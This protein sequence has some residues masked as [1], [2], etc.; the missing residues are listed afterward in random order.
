[1]CEKSALKRCFA[2]FILGTAFLLPNCDLAPFHK[3]PERFSLEFPELPPAWKSLLG[4]PLWRIEW[5][6]SEGRKEMMTVRGKAEIAL[7]QTW[8]NPVIAMPFW[9]G[10]GIGHGI[11][12]PA[13]AIFPFDVSGNSLVLS[14]QGGLDAT[15]YWELAIAYDAAGLGYDRAAVPRLPHYFDWQRFRL[16]FTDPSLNAE[17][18]ADPW[19]ADWRGIAAKIVQS[20]F[21]KRRLVPESRSV[22][23]IPVHSGPWIGTSPFAPPL[24]FDAV[25][26]FPVRPTADTWVSA[27]GILRCSAEAWI[28]ME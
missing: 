10:K 7:P 13:G 22:R 18:R 12:M 23:E 16:L 3:E 1:M 6:N 21:D 9:P 24:V 15:L 25:P 26:A 8:A 17:I 11:F 20:G 27:E 4:Y 19:L 5:L 14:W 2:A 28:L